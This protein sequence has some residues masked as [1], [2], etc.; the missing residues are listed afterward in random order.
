[1]YPSIMICL[2]HFVG[3]FDFLKILFI[4]FLFS[5]SIHFCFICW[6]HWLEVLIKTDN[7]EYIHL[8][9]ATQLFPWIYRFL[10]PFFF[11]LAPPIKDR[12]LLNF[13][14]IMFQFWSLTFRMMF[15]SVSACVYTYMQLPESKKLCASDSW[16]HIMDLLLTSFNFEFQWIC[17]V[18]V[19]VYADSNCLC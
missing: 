4:F 12:L 11:I 17:F 18:C 1:M 19:R 7:G 16:Y 13:D 15:F 2:L 10:S 3:Y 6:I 14:V 8:S 9:N 5:A